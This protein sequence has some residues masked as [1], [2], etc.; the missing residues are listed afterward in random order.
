MIGVLPRWPFLGVPSGWT[1]WAIVFRVP[2]YSDWQ[3]LEYKFEDTLYIWTVIYKTGHVMLHHQL[4]SASN[5]ADSQ[6][7]DAIDLRQRLGKL[8]CVRI[9]VGGS[10]TL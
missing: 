3:G 9:L 10:Q 4:I 7:Y 6:R 5:D 2:P 1:F 8:Y